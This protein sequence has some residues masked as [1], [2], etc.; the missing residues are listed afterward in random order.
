MTAL[1]AALTGTTGIEGRS[2][3]AGSP[4]VP[5]TLPRWTPLHGTRRPEI[6]GEPVFRGEV[7]APTDART[8]REHH[9]RARAELPQRALRLSHGDPAIP[10]TY[11]DDWS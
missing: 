3:G 7:V 5:P 8:A 1:T 4:R 2:S 9:E 6:L 11:L 10:T